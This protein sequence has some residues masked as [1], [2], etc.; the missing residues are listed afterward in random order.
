MLDRLMA[1]LLNGPAMNCRPHRSRQRIDFTSLGLFQDVAPLDALKAILGQDESIK[2]VSRVP[3][4]KSSRKAGPIDP[5][6]PTTDEKDPSIA[7]GQIVTKLRLMTQ[8]A[9][10]YRQDTG[11]HVLSIGFP[12]LALPPGSLGRDNQRRVIAPICF[13]PVEIELTRGANVSVKISCY[14]EGTDR[15]VP[16]VALFAWLERLTGG[17]DLMRKFED[18]LGEKPMREIATLVGEACRALNMP[19]PPFVPA[20]HTDSPGNEAPDLQ[21]P[22][23]FTLEPAPTSDQLGDHPRVL[24]C[25]VIGLFPMA[26]QALIEDTKALAGGEKLDGPVA[27]FVQVGLSLGGP[28]PLPPSRAKDGSLPTGP[29][30]VRLVADA[31]PCQREVVR[32][33]RSARGVVVH[34]PPGTGKSQTIVNIIGDHL[35]RGQ[36]VLFVSDKRTALDVVLNRLDSVGIAGLGAVVHDPKVDQ[37]DFYRR[38]RDQLDELMDAKPDSTVESKLKAVESE[39]TEIHANLSRHHRALMQSEP[40]KPSFSDLVGRWLAL[41]DVSSQVMKHLGAISLDAI[42]RHQ[43]NLK[44]MLDRATKS[45][46]ANN[47]WAGFACEDVGAILARSVDDIRSSARSLLEM[48]GRIDSSII[49]GAPALFDI[50]LERQVA[51]RERLADAIE[52]IQTIPPAAIDHISKLDDARIERLRPRVEELRAA[53]GSARSTRLDAALLERAKTTPFGPADFARQMVELDEYLQASRGLLGFLAFSKKNAAA[54]VL[55]PFG[56]STNPDSASR[57]RLFIEAYRHRQLLTFALAEFSGMSAVG[58]G[59]MVDDELFPGIDSALALVEVRLLAGPGRI[60]SEFVQSIWTTS[61]RS[62]MV[63]GLRS[64]SKR[65]EVASVLTVAAGN[66]KLFSLQGIK[67]LREM[68]LSNQPITPRIEKM[69]EQLDSYE[70]IARVE[71]A[72]SELPVEV[73][74]TLRALLNSGANAEGVINALEKQALQAE[75]SKRLAA[76]PT[77]TDYDAQKLA[78]MFDRLVDLETKRREFVS[79]QVVSFWTS[80]VRQRLLAPTGNRLSTLGADLKRRFTM[81]GK[82]AMRLRKV[83]ALGSVIEGGDPLFDLRPVWMASPETVAQ[84]FKR[85]PIFDVVVFDEASQCRLEETLPVL[86]RGKRIV[87]AGDEH[88]LPPTRFFE[89]A[90]EADDANEATD[91]QSLFEVQQ[92][93]TED[94]LS[95][96]LQLEIQEAYLDVHYRSKSADLI[97]FSNEYFYKSRLQPIPAPPSN[98]PTEPSVRLVRADGTYEKSVNEIEAQKIVEIVRQLL[99]QTKPPTI[100]I[101][102]MNVQQRDAISDALDSAADTDESFARKLDTARERVGSGGFEGLFVKN[103][104]NIQ[105][106]E[107]DH[108]IISTTYGPDKNGKFFRRFGPLGQAGGGRRLNVLVTRAKERVHVVTSIPAGAYRALPPVPDRQQPAGSWLLLAYLK[109]AEELS[110]RFAQSETS[111][112]LAE[113]K[114]I[115]PSRLVDAV[116]ARLLKAD[117]LNQRYL[118]NDGFCIDL[119]VLN[120]SSD[121]TIRAGL[122][123]DAT[124]FEGSPDAVGWDVFRTFTLRRQGWFFERMWSPHIFRDPDGLVRQITGSVLGNGA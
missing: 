9:F 46:Y 11:V 69:I 35:A 104:E 62:E 20:D 89:T 29:I 85:Q 106:D 78:S 117:V 23:E 76:D 51:A 4:P 44:E 97:A 98:K 66:S 57:L 33:S 109:F 90:L 17:Q 67:R 112:V 71:K 73:G 63:R 107:R 42:S 121:P 5:N 92:S 123:I 49:P 19:I 113:V 18:E 100:G 122:L 77:F 37:R 84:L 59:V 2:L 53:L 47:A 41:P 39:I 45:N 105:G 13:V 96:A 32:L 75:I 118:G 52:R 54:R 27:S 14:G 34:G 88:Q 3:L 114:S 22:G 95:A 65:V 24:P 81:S 124:R 116:S 55:T 110:A 74:Q 93:N 115:M 8:D 50:D 119:G 60:G 21:L 120:S 30:S 6:S 15:V 1:G 102:A 83:V 72:L 82:N 94:L 25:A 101:A 56:L 58:T 38:V 12:L 80:K 64:A 99:D 86:T 103:L 10:T 61:D 111:P 70:S 87:I 16:N 108:I 28:P 68:I 43:A 26:N 79:K 31:D 91:D 48:A 40:G 7:F 36:R